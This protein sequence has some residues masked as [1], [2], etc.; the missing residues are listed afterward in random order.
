MSSRV[1]T[2]QVI[3]IKS[4]ISSKEN[5]R[6]YCVKGNINEELR[7]Y[8]YLFIYVYKY[9]LYIYI[10]IYIYIYTNLF[11]VRKV[12]IAIVAGGMESPMSCLV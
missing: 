8:M 1:I 12:L 9:I 3:K 4:L 10:Y 6:R 11:N 5:L 2:P 7:K